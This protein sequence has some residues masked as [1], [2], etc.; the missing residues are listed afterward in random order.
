M[1]LKK[2]SLI[3]ASVQIRS[4]SG[5]AY[6][7]GHLAA[8][9]PACS[10]VPTHQLFLRFAIKIRLVCEERSMMTRSMGA[11][12]RG[13]GAGARS[14]I[15]SRGRGAGR[16]APGALRRPPPLRLFQITIAFVP[17]ADRG[18]RVFFLLALN[19]QLPLR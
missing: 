4:L 18:A 1:L 10:A 14:Q 15:N 19:G 13:A 11:R 5:R 6:A 7:V 2:S 17:T 16:T 9:P 8:A 3:I 12:R